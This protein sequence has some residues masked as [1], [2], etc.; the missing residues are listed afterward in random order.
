MKANEDNISDLAV[1]IGT[2][3][4]EWLTGHVIESD[5]PMKA[6]VDRMRDES[7]TTDEQPEKTNAATL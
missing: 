1:E 4:R 2:F 6:Y 5:L 3:L 7:K